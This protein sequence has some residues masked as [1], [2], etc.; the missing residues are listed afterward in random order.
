MFGHV[1][2]DLEMDEFI[3]DMCVHGFYVYQDVWRP[4]IGQELRCERDEDN[5]K[6]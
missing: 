4:A 5:D 2:N 1:S 6:D 3:T